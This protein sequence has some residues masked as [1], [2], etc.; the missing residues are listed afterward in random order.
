MFDLQYIG[1][2]VFRADSGN[3]VTLCHAFNQTGLILGWLLMIRMET[4]RVRQ[5][6]QE[7]QRTE[8]ARLEAARA[9]AEAK[10]LEAERSR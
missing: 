2:A 4:A 5:V 9:A 8:R 1:I 6:E 10:K 7:K 3:F